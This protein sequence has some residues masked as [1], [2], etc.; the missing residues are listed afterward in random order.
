MNGTNKYLEHKGDAGEDERDAMGI[1]A[2]ADEGD[3][4]RTKS[5]TKSTL[6]RPLEGRGTAAS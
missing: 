4:E 6:R 3:D 2:D 1:E 5:D